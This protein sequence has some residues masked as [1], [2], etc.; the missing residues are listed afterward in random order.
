[1]RLSSRSGMDFLSTPLFPQ[2]THF[3]PG[4]RHTNLPINQIPIVILKK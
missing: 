2:L 4:N 3:K 1:M